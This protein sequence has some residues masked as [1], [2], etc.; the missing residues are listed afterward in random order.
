MNILYINSFDCSPDSS[1]GVNRIVFVLSRY[2]Q[3]KLEYRCFL[4]FY[5]NQPAGRLLAPFYDRIQL[6]KDFREEEFEDFL[7]RNDIDVI[8][9]NFLKKENIYT[10]PLIFRIAQKHHIKVLY[11]LHVCP[12]FETVAYGSWLRVKYSIVYGD[13][14]LRELRR[15][16]ITAIRPLV[17][18]VA[19]RIIRNKYLMPYLNCDNVVLLSSNYRKPY[20]D[21]IGMKESEKFKAIGNALT[22]DDFASSDDIKNKRKEVLVVARFDEFSKRISLALKVWKNIEKDPRLKDWNLTLVGTGEAE[23]FYKYLVK[24][25]KLNRVVFTGL[26]KP[27]E[28]YRRASVFLMT[29]SAEGWPMVLMEASQMG[30]P[31]VAFDSF[32]ALHDIVEDGYNGRI[33]QNNDLCAFQ[34]ALVSIMMNDTHRQQMGRNAVVKSHE[35]EINSIV[36]KWQEVYGFVQ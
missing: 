24:K 22:F 31:T 7:I 27:I 12:G 17:K 5:E 34:D 2:L 30:V 11:C 26:Q 35:F 8:Q 23:G 21:I 16:L 6:H 32:G 29:S 3:E 19:N 25:W 20:L 1:G 4:G 36:E 9:V 33:I 14:P 28:Y 18:P 15:W 13:H 10:I